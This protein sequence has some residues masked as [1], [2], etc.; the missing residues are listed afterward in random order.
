MM[1]SPEQGF[2]AVPPPTGLK[3]DIT[4]LNAH[5]HNGNASIASHNPA[6]TE[7]EHFLEK[8]IALS[9]KYEIPPEELLTV[10]SFETGGTLDP[11]TT[12]SLGYTGLIQFGVESAYD[13]GTSTAALRRM[14]RVEQLKWVDAYF[15]QRGLPKQA[16]I[17]QLYATILVG[18][19]SGN[20]HATDANGTSVYSAISQDFPAHR[21]KAIAL[22]KSVRKQSVGLIHSPLCGV[23][24][25]FV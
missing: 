23:M 10:M 15:S 13:L 20:I 17:E 2:C 21:E 3:L 4:P 7:T 25:R 22:L 18:N 1:D 12:N 9:K 24:P 16:T 11:K 14:S 19:P 6:K 8:T 5:N